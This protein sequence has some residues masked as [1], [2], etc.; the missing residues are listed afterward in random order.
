[1]DYKITIARPWR[2]RHPRFGS[3][4]LDPGMYSVPEQVTD[5][6]ARQAL[7]QGVAIRSVGQSVT[8]V[9]PPVEAPPV[10]R[11]KRKAKGP[12]PDNRALGVAP[13]NKQALF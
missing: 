8:H 7:D 2:Y 10:R 12:A 9:P 5:S 11:K 4:V 3:Q 13:E 6:I 1:M